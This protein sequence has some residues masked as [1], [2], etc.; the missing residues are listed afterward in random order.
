M[1]HLAEQSVDEAVEKFVP[2]ADM[3]V[4]R[5]GRHPELL[6]EAPHSECLH[7]VKIDQ[8]GRGI[9]DRLG[10]DGL[11][12]PLALGVSAGSALRARHWFHP[13]SFAPI[14][15]ARDSVRGCGA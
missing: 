1:R 7:P 12:S 14:R 15:V 8:A 2:P 9:K 13:R 4:D 6:S 3:P 11:L 10:A 5:G